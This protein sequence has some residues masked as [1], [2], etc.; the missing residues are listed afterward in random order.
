[1]L[2]R[3]AIGAVLLI[4]LLSVASWLLRETPSGG[5]PTAAPAPQPDAGMPS[6]MTSPSPAAPSPGGATGELPPPTQS[7]QA[8]DDLLRKPSALSVDQ[9]I[10]T[11]DALANDDPTAAVRAAGELLVSD[12][13]VDVRLRAIDILDSVDDD[14]TVDVL[15]Q[16]L[17]DREP[18]VR[19][20]AA[21]ALANHPA[22][23]S[24]EP[25]QAALRSEREEDVANEL[26]NAL[27][28]LGV[29]TEQAGQN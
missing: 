1:M 11:L 16:G 24:I 19:I 12:P 2:R 15:A 3:I 5:A 20:G 28:L 17:R 18:D 6:S 21:E 4:A 7:K 27:E 13:D 29:D 8:L 26:K 22:P 25:L 14:S 9:R 23:R 10:D